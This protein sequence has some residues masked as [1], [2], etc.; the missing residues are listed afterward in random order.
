MM[1][2]SIS[3][4]AADIKKPFPGMYDGGT[5]LVCWSVSEMDVIGSLLF[6]HLFE[7]HIFDLE[8]VNVTHKQEC[9]ERIVPE[10]E[11]AG[12]GVGILSQL[13][14]FP[15]GFNT[16]S[17]FNGT[18]PQSDVFH[19]EIFHAADVAALTAGVEDMNIFQQNVSEV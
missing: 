18:I 13:G 6:G 12:E 9:R 4:E 3:A 2:F 16:F 19:I 11:G 5:A 8:V 7:N 14:I 10:S 15:V 17:N 1:F